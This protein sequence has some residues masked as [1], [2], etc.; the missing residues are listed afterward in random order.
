MSARSIPKE[1]EHVLAP[2]APSLIRE[3]V[4]LYGVVEAPGSRNNPVIMGWVRVVEKALKT[5]DL[6]FRTLG[7]TSDAVPWCGLYF[8]VVAVRAGW[9]DQMP[10]A[11]LWAR[12]GLQFGRKVS[13]PMF[14]DVLVFSRGGG[15]HIGF[16]VGEDVS[17]YHVLGGNQSD[18]VTITRIAKSRL[19]GARR[20]KW[21]VAQ[22]ASVRKI[23]MGAHGPLST[24]E[25]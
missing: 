13:T 4:K 25:A 24:N 19:L 10:M 5:R 8:G 20:P 2:G 21:R 14:G 9:T 6:G 23:I 16:Y 12:N 1:Y 7:Y 18:A 3:A 15:G 17:A 11:P 22:P